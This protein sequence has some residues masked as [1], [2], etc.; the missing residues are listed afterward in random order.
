MEKQLTNKNSLVL[1]ASRI[2]TLETCSWTYWCNYHLKLPQKTNSGA[3]RGTICHLV[4]ELLLSKR[5]LSHFKKII[6]KNQ[7][8]ASS[9]ITRLVDKHVK[10]QGLNEEDRKMIGEMILVG[11]NQD[12]FG[13]KGLVGEAEQEFII[14]NAS[15]EYKI[16]GFIDKN[17]YYEKEGLVKII[18][19]KSSKAKFKEEELSS[20]VQAMTYSLASFKNLFPNAKKVIAE[21]IFLRF[22]KQPIQQIEIPK[23]QLSGFEYYLA[24][25]YKKAKEFTEQD[26]KTN[27]AAS[28]KETKWLC[29]AGKTWRCPYLDS[30]EYFVLLDS[31]DKILSSSF[32]DDFKLK[33]SQ[34]IEKRKYEGCPAHKKQ[35]EL[36]KDSSFDDF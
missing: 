15:P 1:S 5:H 16:K 10:K 4:F 31:D 28:N 34:R 17:V 36:I 21:F 30:F 19:Y 33:E 25:I 7:I 2:K 29:Q 22:P 11:I 12:F 18:D 32:K 14:E 8:E 6:K 35:S 26:A 3:L 23:D 27:Y 24:F 20:N 9:A 13:K